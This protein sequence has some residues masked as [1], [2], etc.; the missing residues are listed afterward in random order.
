MMIV[1]T[2]RMPP[3][4]AQ[5]TAAPFNIAAE[6]WSSQ[7]NRFRKIVATSLDFLRSTEVQA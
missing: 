1:A 2:Q 5:Y 3:Q 4:L 6:Q 7:E